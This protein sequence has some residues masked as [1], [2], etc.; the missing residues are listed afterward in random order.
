[1]KIT[2]KI[3][4]LNLVI[5]LFISAITGLYFYKSAD[6][7]ANSIDNDF[8]YSFNEQNINLFFLSTTK[9]SSSLAE[10]QK[11]KQEVQ[12]NFD[13]SFKCSFHFSLA[14]VQLDDFLLVVKE[15][16]LNLLFPFHE[17]S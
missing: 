2:Q 14:L 13:F 4:A 6:L 8:S 9:E 7:K 3:V 16:I 5:A 17:F 12:L 15:G 1:M 10:Q 11:S